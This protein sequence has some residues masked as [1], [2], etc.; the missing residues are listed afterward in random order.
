MKRCV[1]SLLNPIMFAIFVLNFWHFLFIL[2]ILLTTVK[3]Q[4]LVKGWFIGILVYALSC[5]IFDAEFV[6][7][8]TN[9][10]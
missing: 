4:N 10:L 9:Y 3:A 5:Y 8:I 2:N 1:D 7:T 6:V